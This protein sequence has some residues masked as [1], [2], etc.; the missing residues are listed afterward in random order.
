[1]VTNKE[2]SMMT[3]TMLPMKRHTDRNHH[4]HHEIAS[5]V[6]GHPIASITNCGHNDSI[7]NTTDDEPVL[8][9]LYDTIVEP[10][11]H[12]EMNTSV[13]ANLESSNV[14]T[15]LDG[16]VAA[17]TTIMMDGKQNHPGVT[18][19]RNDDHINLIP[20]STYFDDDDDDILEFVAFPTCRQGRVSK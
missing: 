19:S 20:T 5:I 2:S 14:D 6:L 18:N 4:S 13:V 15:C 10:T 7:V 1:M 3:K 8:E 11:N 16:D 17:G 12:S 9:F